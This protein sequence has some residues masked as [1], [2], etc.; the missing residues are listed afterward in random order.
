M[1]R[2]PSDLFLYDLFYEIKESNGF[3][4]FLFKIQRTKQIY[5][6]TKERFY[7]FSTNLVLDGAEYMFY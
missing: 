6:C 7:L 4:Y 2:K 5:D 3:R 1:K